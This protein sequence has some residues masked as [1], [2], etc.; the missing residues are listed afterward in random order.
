MQS[1]L[2]AHS[3]G[4]RRALGQNFVTD[5]SVIEAMVAAAGVGP[6]SRVVEVGPG[7]GSLTLGLL[8]AGAHVV[9][10]E[11]DPALAEV[12][13]GVLDARG[14]E[15]VA[16][17]GAAAAGSAA[18]DA[19]RAH[20]RVH[21]GDA[22]GVS[23][24]DLLDAGQEGGWKLV[25]NLPYNVAVPVVLD[26]LQTAPMVQE[27]WVMVQLE[28]A[29]RL[30]AQP[31]GR[32]IGVPTVKAAWYSRSRIVMEVP[33]QAFTPEPLVTSAVVELKRCGSPR[34]DVDATAVFDLVESAYRK[35]RKM[36]RSSLGAQVG[37]GAFE[38]AGVDPTARPEELSVA[39][40]ANLAVSHRVGAQ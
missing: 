19:S 31:G 2:D 35:R 38:A 13:R 27:L 24:P 8:E 28:V 32:A 40:W 36:L 22:L 12:L 5:P 34:D 23:W 15:V 4:P 37:A 7:L 6:G 3:L 1:L 14:Y 30:C 10:V 16:G 17:G 20:A 18:A 25:S 26:V 33:P 11:K 39:D 21:T 29:Q 9:A